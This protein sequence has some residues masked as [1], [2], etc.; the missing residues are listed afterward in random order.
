MVTITKERPETREKVTRRPKSPAVQ[1]TEQPEHRVS[2]LA[3][4][5][6]SAKAVAQP[7]DAHR[8]PPAGPF[9]KLARGLR[10]VFFQLG[11]SGPS[12]PYY[13]DGR[14]FGPR[15]D[16]MRTVH[17][18]GLYYLGGRAFPPRTDAVRDAQNKG[19]L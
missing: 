2:P 14:G 15:N 9:S 8:D 7:T 4:T 13:S 12:N 10:D 3:Q 11:I 1:Q 5:V 19:V 6:G 18:M 16:P 17:K